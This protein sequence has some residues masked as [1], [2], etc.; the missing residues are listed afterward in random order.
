[1]AGTDYD[2]AVVG[3]SIAGCTAATLYARGGARVALIEKSPSPEHYKVM[4]THFIQPS[5]I[6]TIDRVGILG[7]LEAAGA[8]RGTVDLWTRFGWVHQPLATELP[9]DEQP[10][11]SIRREKLDPIL[12]RA[13]AETAGVDLLAGQTVTGLLA[14]DGRVTGV[15]VKD[16]AGTLRDITARLVVAADG[17]DSQMAAMARVPARLMPH[18]RA[19]YMAYYTGIQTPRPGAAQLWLTDPDIAY[20]F[21]NDDGVTV[22]A[23]FVHKRRLSEFKRDLEGSMMTIFDPL[24]DAPDVR[25]GTRI[26]KVLGKLELTNRSRPPAARGMAFV[27]DAAMA[28]DPVWGVG[29]GWA[30]QSAEWLVDCTAAEV[31]TGH[32]LDRALRRYLRRHRARL[33]PH[34]FL[35]SDFASGRPLNAVERM[36]FGAGVTD[37]AVARA[38]RLYGGRVGSPGV[39]FSPRVLAGMARSA[40]GLRSVEHAGTNGSAASGPSVR[41]ASEETALVG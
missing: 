10:A 14:S 18:N 9:P 17:R 8:V 6:P 39:L 11:L 13:A 12:R 41:N 15:S 40:R 7:A 29:C 30:F 31:R 22:L 23:C 21:P 19:G 16:R 25:A 1:M 24:P 35:I 37:P 33:G 5:S 28:A 38:L 34:H 36:Q 3:A 2:V 20:V 26:S 27:G 32:G 4:C